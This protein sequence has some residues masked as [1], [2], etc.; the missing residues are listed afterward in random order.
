MARLQ[1]MEGVKVVVTDTRKGI[2]LYNEYAE[3]Q[4][5]VGGLFHSTC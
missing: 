4:L 3:Q 2:E 1:T 5:T